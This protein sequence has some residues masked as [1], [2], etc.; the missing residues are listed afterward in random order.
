MD[1]SGNINRTVTDAN[2]LVGRLGKSLGLW[3]GTILVVGLDSQ[4]LSLVTL[5]GQMQY[6]FAR[7]IIL[8][9]RMQRNERK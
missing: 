1:D 2:L 7:N 9:L 3:I 6:G 5:N 4:R 8:S